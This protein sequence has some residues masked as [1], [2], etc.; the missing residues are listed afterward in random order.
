M[1]LI[2]ACRDNAGERCRIDGRNADTWSHVFHK[3]ARFTQPRFD[4]Y[5]Q[6]LEGDGLL[7]YE[8]MK[9]T[10]DE[11]TGIYDL[12]FTATAPPTPVTIRMQL[13]FQR[14]D[15]FIEDP[16]RLTL[17]PI[18]IEADQK[19]TNDVG[20]T[21]RVNH[22]GYSELFQSKDRADSSDFKNHKDTPTIRKNNFTIIRT[23]TARF[24]SGFPNGDNPTR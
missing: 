9:L 4:M 21:L 7:I 8:G 13:H 17:P 22:R 23:G 6:R 15:G 10:V 14:N 1:E 12:T 19:A 11:N 5:Q 18:R 2:G 24:G 16:I 20:T 3:A